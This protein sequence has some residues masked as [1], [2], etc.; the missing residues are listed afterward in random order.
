MNPYCRLAKPGETPSE[1][2]SHII[3]EGRRFRARYELS[4]DPSVIKDR[5]RKKAKR[6]GTWVPMSKEELSKIYSEAAKKRWAASPLSMTKDAIRKRNEKLKNASVR[7][8]V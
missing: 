8:A 4:Q 3:E 2:P 5:L 7:S 1:W 6:E